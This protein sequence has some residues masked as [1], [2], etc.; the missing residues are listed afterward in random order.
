M[1][2][3]PLMMAHW[4]RAEDCQQF[5]FTSVGKLLV[6]TNGWASL[7]LKLQVKG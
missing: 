2:V 1:Q 4:D 5:I 6:L 7:A 3:L